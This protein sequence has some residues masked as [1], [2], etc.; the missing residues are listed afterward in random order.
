[1]T[2]SF[3]ILRKFIWNIVRVQFALLFLILVIDGVEQLRIMAKYEAP[4][5]DAMKLTLLRANGYVMQIFPLVIMLAALSTFVGLARSSELVI[6]RAAGQSALR[7]LVIPVA[8]T[9]LIGTFMTA[10]YNPIVAATYRQADDILNKYNVGGRSLVS[11][12]ADGIWLRQ[13]DDDSQFVIHAERASLNGTILFRVGWHEFATDGHLIR[14]IEAV[15]AQLFEGEWIVRSGTEWLFDPSNPD[16]AMTENVFE[17]LRLPTNLTSQEILK[18]FASPKT[19]SI[20][21]LPALVRQLESS[22]F[23]THRQRL[24]IQTEMSRPLMLVAMVLIGAG[25]SMR[26][27]RFGQT[28]VMVLIA[29]FSAFILY[30][31]QSVAISLGSA[32]EISLM[33][34]AWGPPSAGI[35]LTMGLLLHLEDG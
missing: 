12:S 28:G 24:F 22:G 3:Y 8:F 15:R 10:I 19:V 32:Q 5:S 14:R 1:M 17:E 2:L 31:M 33:L 20:W 23:S 18:N 7:L 34:A 16:N 35:L 29:V 21:E 6:S 13:G 27:S 4:V 25:F 30:S 26:P 9:L 11:L